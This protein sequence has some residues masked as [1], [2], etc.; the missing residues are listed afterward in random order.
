M[1]W[2]GAAS[3]V[4]GANTSAARNNNGSAAAAAEQVAGWLLALAEPEAATAQT[5]GARSSPAEPRLE[6]EL[7]AVESLLEETF[8]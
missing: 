2:P 7:S 4:G 8:E 6:A 3:A 1:N 5:R